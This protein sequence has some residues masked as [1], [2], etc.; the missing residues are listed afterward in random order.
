MTNKSSTTILV[1]DDNEISR[2]VTMEILASYGFTIDEACDGFKAFER[3]CLRRYDL[4]FMDQEMPNMDGIA[5]MKKIRAYE[6]EHGIPHTPIALLTASEEPTA[7]IFSFQYYLQKPLDHTHI[8]E[9]MEELCLTLP[10]L[11]ETD[12][13]LTTPTEREWFAAFKALS[14]I[15]AN[16]ALRHTGSLSLLM[17]IVECFSKELKGELE[18]FYSKF[19]AMDFD[20]IRLRAHTL[21]HSSFLIGAVSLSESSR[22]AEELA[23]E[24]NAHKLRSYLPDL[25][26][27]YKDLGNA[28]KAFETTAKP[29]PSMGPIDEERFHQAL[30]DIRELAQAY[31]YTDG[32]LICDMLRDHALTVEQAE[33]VDRIYDALF[34]SDHELILKQLPG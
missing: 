15:D 27:E 7:D 30:L 10:D 17:H 11:L 28:L 8:R 14:F 34:K 16:A 3:V 19:E 2:M 6:D 33:K 22:K 18:D 20:G 26:T 29:A 9:L 21:K 24:K 12:D 25:L 13:A 31:D 23:K 4:I 1:V 5:C 32:Q